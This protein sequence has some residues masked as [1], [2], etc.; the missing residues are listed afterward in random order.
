MIVAPGFIDLHTHY[1]AQPS[2]T[3][4]SLSGWHGVTSVVIGNCGLA[5]AD[6]A[7]M[8]SAML[9]MTA[10]PRHSIE[11]MKQGMFGMDHLP[12]P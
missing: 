12:G 9:T 2:G 7:E 1:D 4:L 6:Q 11:S 5:R 8:R 10:L 3:V